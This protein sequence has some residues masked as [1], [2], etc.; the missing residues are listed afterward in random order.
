MCCLH[1]KNLFHLLQKNCDSSVY[2]AYRGI[3]IVHATLDNYKDTL[4]FVLDTGSGGISI[5]STT[6]VYLGLTKMSDRTV[7]G[8]AGMKTVEF[9]YNHTLH[10]PGIT[11]ENLDFHIND[12]DILTSAYGMRIDGIIGYSFYVDI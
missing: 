2:H 4:N 7:R 10:M 11:V 6:S 5:D 12:Y 1:R 8:I 9:S 3:I